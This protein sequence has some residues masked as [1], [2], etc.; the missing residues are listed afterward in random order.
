MQVTGLLLILSA[1]VAGPAEAQEKKIPKFQIRP[2]GGPAFPDQSKVKAI[3]LA[4]GNEEVARAIFKGGSGTAEIIEDSSFG[5][6][7]GLEIGYQLK[8]GDEDVNPAG[9]GLKAGILLPPGLVL[10]VKTSDGTAFET[11]LTSSL[12]LAMPGFWVQSRKPTGF[13]YRA[14]FNVGIG[15]AGATTS[16]T[17]A[18]GTR[19]SD[20]TGLGAVFEGSGEWGYA[21]NQNFRVFIQASYL[22]AKISK[23]KAMDDDGVTRVWPDRNTDKPL[24]F[25]FSGLGLRLGTGLAF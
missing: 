11:T 2:W 17:D 8:A 22:H 4:G 16:H 1:V 21:I 5:I 24:A 15:I 9:I 10:T 18:L 20:A 3:I 7:A 12:I 25:N 13:H 6:S 14:S 23:M 19:A